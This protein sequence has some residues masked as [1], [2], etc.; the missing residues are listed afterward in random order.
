M[1]AKPSKDLTCVIPK[2]TRKTKT[3]GATHWKKGSQKKTHTKISY[4][5]TTNEWNRKGVNVR[6]G[7]KARKKNCFNTKKK[8]TR[9]SSLRIRFTYLLVTT[10]IDAVRVKGYQF[11]V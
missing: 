4:S 5:E 11:S 9:G 1:G 6:S 7:F 3:I 8:Q 10:S 2:Y